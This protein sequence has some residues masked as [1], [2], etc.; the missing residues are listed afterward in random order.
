MSSDRTIKTLIT[1]CLN[2]PVCKYVHYAY[3][4]LRNGEG[5]IAIK[6]KHVRD[7]GKTLFVH[8]CRW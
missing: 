7:G 5:E 6:L 8:F 4:C 1:P 2:K 3:N